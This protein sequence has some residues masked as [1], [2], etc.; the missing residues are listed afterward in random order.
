ME[1]REPELFSRY[2]VVRNH[3]EFRERCVVRQKHNHHEILDQSQARVLYFDLDCKDPDK[4]KD[5]DLYRHLGTLL[6][7]R[8]LTVDALGQSN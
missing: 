1:T 7:M 5:H 2:G 3:D 8:A 6:T 4:R